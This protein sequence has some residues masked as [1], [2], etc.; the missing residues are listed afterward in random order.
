MVPERGAAGQDRPAALD[1]GLRRRSGRT[2]TCD[3]AP[4]SPLDKY[5]SKS[6]EEKA[7][8]AAQFIKNF[9]WTAEHQNTVSDYITN[10]AMSRE[11]AAKKW[12][13][14]NEAVWQAWIPA[15]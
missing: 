7:P 11:D 3:Y 6:L 13:D 10:D 9:S 5:I 4:Y 14:E 2:I 12:V 1:R 8:R 15:S